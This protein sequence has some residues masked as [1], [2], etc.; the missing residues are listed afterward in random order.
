VLHHSARRTNT[1]NISTFNLEMEVAASS[2]SCWSEKIL[3]ALNID[4]AARSYRHALKALPMTAPCTLSAATRCCSCG[5][6]SSTNDVH[7]LVWKGSAGRW[8]GK[9]AL[10]EI[11][12]HSREYAQVIIG[13]HAWPLHPF[14]PFT[15]P[16]PQSTVRFS[17]LAL[18][19]IAT[20]RQTR[21]RFVSFCR[22]VSSSSTT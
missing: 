15:S 14:E 21:T 19:G 7:G 18:D 5:S 8:V 1:E 4:T 13:W 6:S 17:R 20:L 16:R 22:T 2:S 3:S 9:R 10:K 11:S 12:R